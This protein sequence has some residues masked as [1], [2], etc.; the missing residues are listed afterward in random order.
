MLRETNGY[1]CE[2]WHRNASKN[3]SRNHSWMSAKN[4]PGQHCTGAQ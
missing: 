4:N 3:F 2:L 1:E